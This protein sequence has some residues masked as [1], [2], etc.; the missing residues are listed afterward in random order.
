MTTYT[1]NEPTSATATELTD[2]SFVVSML[3]PPCLVCQHTTKPSGCYN[4]KAAAP[5]GIC[6][7]CFFRD[8]TPVGVDPNLP[9]TNPTPPMPGVPV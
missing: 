5:N 7:A 9:G 6:L 3:Y 2:G 8:T 1:I 4:C